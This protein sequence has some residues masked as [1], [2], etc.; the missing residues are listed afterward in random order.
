MS[1]TQRLLLVAF[2]IV[3]PA[4]A[5]AAADRIVDVNGVKL[6]LRCDGERQPGRPLVVL[7][8][9]AQ[10]SMK[11]WD[12]VLPA[13][14]TFARVCAYD[15]AGMGESDP[16]PAGQTAAEIV[17]RLRVLLQRAGEA[18]PYVMVG[19]SYG[20][21]IAM[22]YAVRHASDIHGL[23]LVDSSHEAQVERL[24]S[25]PGAA[26]SPPPAGRAESRDVLNMFE[27]L[28]SSP[29]RGSVPLVVL[30]RGQWGV[31]GTPPDIADRRLSAWRALQQD[32]VTR[33]NRGVQVVAGES[34]HYIQTTE[35]QLVID[36]IRR[37][38]SDRTAKDS[39]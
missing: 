7:E 37:V 21:A 38:F 20:G 18:P 16:A 33:S 23:V 24:G 34:G 8:A 11:T 1:H 13:T 22:L 5:H 4:A 12:Q 9:G 2:L 28:R 26:K 30:T 3:A 25:L 31:P 36:A 27:A 32:L 10:D 15:R 29:W 19:H 6:H 39:R 14:A 35:P 17:D